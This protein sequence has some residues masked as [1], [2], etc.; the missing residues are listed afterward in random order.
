M[1]PK[2]G[3]LLVG[4]TA[5]QVI[6]FIVCETDGDHLVQSRTID[7]FEQQNDQIREKFKWK[8]HT[9]LTVKDERHFEP[10]GYQGN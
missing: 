2:T 6:V 5:G 10:A 1:C 9:Q 7:L 8:G 3:A 4:G